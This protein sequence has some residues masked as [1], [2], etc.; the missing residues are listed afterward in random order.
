MLV[1]L[2]I[3]IHTLHVSADSTNLLPLEI[4]PVCSDVTTGLAHWNVTN[5]N[6]QAISFDWTN[7]SNNAAGTYVAPQG[8]SELLTS[9]NATDP[10]NTTRFVKQDNTAPSQTNAQNVPCT[11]VA[12]V[13]PVTPIVPT[14]P[15]CVDGHDQQNLDVN[16]VT[17]NTVLISA[18]NG[19]VFCNDEDIY[20]SSYIMPADYNGQGFAGNTTA[21]P[22]T[23]FSSDH[24]VTPK[25]QPVD[26]AIT[27]QLPDSCNNTQVDVYYAPEIQTVGPNGHGT[28]NI[29]SQV[30]PSTG[31]C[32]N[33]GG[34]G[35]MGGGPTTPPAPTTPVTSPITGGKGAGP[36]PSTPVVA[37][38]PSAPRSQSPLA[39]P[40]T[41]PDTGEHLLGA[42]ILL[43][44]ITTGVSYAAALGYHKRR[45]S[46]S[47]LG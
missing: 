35:G 47:F 17:K 41:L 3:P 21:Y 44:I 24:V 18:K 46:N 22:Q 8:D 1:L 16:F 11:P 36:L 2:A 28:Q 40:K 14:Q 32:S 43:P 42:L 30:Y 13:T 39:L 27:I 9:Y 12:P 4:V 6:T 45:I 26:E 37:S 5:K 7:L 25:N 15:S 19:A 10:N 29:L 31:S 20:F 38:L 23:I 33:G 34:T